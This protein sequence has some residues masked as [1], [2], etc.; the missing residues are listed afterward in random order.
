MGAL[1]AQAPK[2][3][4]IA[5][6]KLIQRYLEVHMRDSQQ[7]ERLVAALRWADSAKTFEALRKGL[8]EPSTRFAA[9]T[10]TAQ[11]R[12][13]RAW[14]LLGKAIDSPDYEDAIQ[15]L[16]QCDDPS[17]EVKLLEKW[18][19]LDPNAPTNNYLAATI[20]NRQLSTQTIDRLATL[21]FPDYT[22]GSDISPARTAKQVAARAMLCAKVGFPPGLEKEALAFINESIRDKSRIL[23]KSRPVLGTPIRLH[24]GIAWGDN[25][26]YQGSDM[27]LV[28]L[29]EWTQADPH[30]VTFWFHPLSDN[31]CSVG[32]ASTQGTWSVDMIGGEGRIVTGTQV[33][34]ITSA[35]PKEWSKACFQVKCLDVPG[36]TE[37]DRE[38]TIF[39]NDKKVIPRYSFN[40]TLQGLTFQGPV[41]VGSC[42][43]QKIDH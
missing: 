2:P 40:G 17:I 25:R 19:G 6:D 36:R 39:V 30:E 22:P 38:V 28:V 15:A 27:V 23:S 31:N 8:T 1:H 21:A 35:R 11:M 33:E 13:P 5:A 37:K 7:A 12:H 14:E 3:A 41:V 34:H 10:L 32:Y 43:I 4:P 42:S 24:G 26:E 20:Q 29:P 18:Y 9:T 16:W